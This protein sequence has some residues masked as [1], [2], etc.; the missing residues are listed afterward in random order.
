MLAAAPT[1]EQK[2]L[3]HEVDQ[4]LL[5]LKM[6]IP[7]RARE[8]LSAMVEKEDGQEDALVW[9]ALGKARWAEKNLDGAGAA[10]SRAKELGVKSRLREKRWAKAFYREFRD[11]VGSLQI[12]AED[13]PE[14][15]FKAKLAAPLVDQQRRALLEALAGW[16]DKQMIRKTDT[17]FYMPRGKYAFG[18]TRVTVKAGKERVLQASD[19]NAVCTTEPPP[20]VVAVAPALPPPEEKPEVV[21]TAPIPEPEEDEGGILSSPWLWIGIGTVAAAGG[22][23]AAV[24]ATRDSSASFRQVF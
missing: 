12:E 24:L 3:S 19:I 7:E 23:T 20:P 1:A 9:L 5:Y 21:A 8:K 10:V 6:K 18:D 13:C 2:R 17:T 14:V 15:K 16:R 22:A 4:A 11:N